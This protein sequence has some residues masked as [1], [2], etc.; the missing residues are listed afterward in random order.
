M[1]LNISPFAHNKPRPFS[2][3]DVGIV[4][5]VGIGGIGMSGIAEIL[6][7]LGYRVQGSDQ[8][9]NA[10]VKRLRSMG[11]HVA[12]GHAAANLGESAIVVV[13]SA[14]KRDNPEVVAAR[15]AFLPVVRRA[16][17]LGELMR[18]KWSVGVGG[19]HG[20]TTT[21]SMIAAL[22]DAAA[23]D[24]TVVNG[25]IINAYG[26]NARLGKGDWMI[27]ET[28]ES[29]GSF[30]KLP[31]TVCIVTNMDPEHLDYYKDFDAVRR[32]YDA[33]VS[34]IPFYGF[35]VLCVDHPEVQA[36]A[37][38]AT[39]R[40]V[41]SYGFS[42]QADVRAVNVQSARDGSTFDV[43]FT[44]R[45]S[46]K[47]TTIE[48]VR[49][50]VIGLHNVQNAL[51]VLA[52]GWQLGLSETIMRRGLSSFEG[53]R[54]RFTRTGCVDGVTIV[55]DYAHHPVEIRATLKAA[56]QA[57]GEKGRVIA[58]VQPHRYSRLLNLMPDF[59]TCFN[60][61][62]CVIVADVYPAGETPIEGANKEALAEGLR[63]HGHRDVLL[64][65]SPDSLA[66]VIHTIAQ[67]GDYVVCLGAGTIS[68]W[69]HALPDALSA[70]SKKSA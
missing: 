13:S 5:F 31:A 54:R 67:D 1:I 23:L 32:A 59:C 55:D 4:H 36:L 24:P 63:A 56:L 45:Q 53:V 14:I 65:S 57:K 70:L 15:A 69:A 61:A 19:T 2:P 62:D 38:R 26:T 12:I 11:I 44:C 6:H 66:S 8:N 30:I 50:P 49:L 9:E 34:N 21:T 3:L 42:P 48:G 52:I 41:I 60:D 46:D 39:D 58:V 7:S 40:R 37:A 10:N 18:L 68:I 28:D 29:D 20:K 64:L 17:M 25:G 27:V 22:F 51:A 43:H 35:A 33:F 47:T 16:E